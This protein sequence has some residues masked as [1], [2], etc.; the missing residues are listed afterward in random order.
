MKQGRG[1]GTL[2]GD[3]SGC[4]LVPPQTA[5][6]TADPLPHRK[7]SKKEPVQALFCLVL[8]LGIEPG[9]AP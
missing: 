5:G 7:P 1:L 4:A 8:P 2:G 9:T 3:P 6:R